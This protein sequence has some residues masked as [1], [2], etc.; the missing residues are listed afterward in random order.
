MKYK[1]LLFGALISCLVGCNYD[2]VVIG[3]PAK[4]VSILSDEFSMPSPSEIP[5]KEV[6][7][8]LN[9]FSKGRGK[10]EYVRRIDH[11]SGDF[12]SIDFENGGMHGG[13]AANMRKK[14]GTWSIEAKFYFE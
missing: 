2:L 11:Y 4:L 8:I 14:D 6:I 9:A 13:G 3:V 12:A 10:D 1:L 5:K 7:G